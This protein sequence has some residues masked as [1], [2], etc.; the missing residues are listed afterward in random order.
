MKALSIVRFS[1]IKFAYIKLI[2][3]ILLAHYR[4]GGVLVWIKTV[5]ESVKNASYERSQVLR[6]IATHKSI[7]RLKS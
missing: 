5:Q 2:K 4:Q 6:V 3:I 7:A 1:Y